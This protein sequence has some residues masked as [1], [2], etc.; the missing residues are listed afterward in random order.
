[1]RQGTDSKAPKCFSGNKKLGCSGIW[2]DEGEDNTTPECRGCSWFIKN[3]TKKL[4]QKLI[5][6]NQIKVMERGG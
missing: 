1:M 5:R 2:D 6:E 3:Y 4:A